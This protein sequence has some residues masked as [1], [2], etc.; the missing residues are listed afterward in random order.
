MIKTVRDWLLQLQDGRC[1]IL[2]TSRKMGVSHQLLF[3]IIQNPSHNVGI[4]TTVKIYNYFL[5]EFGIHLPPWEYLDVPK[6]KPYHFNADDMENILEACTIDDYQE[7]EE[8]PEEEYKEPM[9]KAVK[10]PKVQV[11]ERMTGHIYVPP[12]KLSPEDE[13]V[14]RLLGLL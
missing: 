5:K 11:P 12:P 9:A 13:E 2:N 7:K 10:L 6:F 14:N 4:Q 3:K 8:E 1:D